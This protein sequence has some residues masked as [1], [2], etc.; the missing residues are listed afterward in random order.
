[1]FILIIDIDNNYEIFSFITYVNVYAFKNN[2][3]ICIA[4]V[5]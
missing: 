4:G 3:Y 2:K 1:M 5:F